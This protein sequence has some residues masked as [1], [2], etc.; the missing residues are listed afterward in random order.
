MNTPTLSNSF[1]S[2]VDDTQRQ[3]LLEAYLEYLHRRNGPIEQGTGRLPLREVS[4]EEMNASEVR[5][6]G[7]ISQTEFERLYANFSASDP[8]L[9]RE[10]LTLL[11][12]CKMNAGEAYGVRVIKAV[13]ARRK[14]QSQ[15]LPSRA[16]LF[17][18]EE[19]EY[20]TRIL[21]GA[22]NYFNIR[23]EG[24][25][26]PKL[27]LR[28]LIGSLAYAPKPL[29]YPIL[30]GAEVAGVFIFNW[31]LNRIR[32]TLQG[33]PELLEAME[34]R[35]IEVIIDEIGHVAFN[36]LV[37]SEA[38][39]LLGRTLAWMTVRGLPSITPE[40]RAMGFDSSALREFDRFD[41]HSLPEEA[42]RR[43]FF[44]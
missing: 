7:Q 29:F 12:F 11:L 3:P 17:A 26:N 31:T 19:E 36:R 33:Q 39:R 1:F 6:A 22:S 32:S 23:A 5:F 42:V 43:G 25:Y 24:T 10:M 21:V 44:A 16:I 2:K 40:L 8:Q 18:Q 13:H 37:L 35:L 9:T 28:V 4:L 41:L 34:Q 20:H 30:Y 38:Q 14:H 27:T 15:D